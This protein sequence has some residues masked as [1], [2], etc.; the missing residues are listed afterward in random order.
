MLQHSMNW[1]R[2]RTSNSN[3]SMWTAESMV[4]TLLYLRMYSTNFS[5]LSKLDPVKAASFVL[6]TGVLWPIFSEL[7][8][9]VVTS[10][11]CAFI[12]FGISW[13]EP[14]LQCHLYLWS[15]VTWINLHTIREKWSVLRILISHWSLKYGLSRGIEATDI[16]VSVARKLINGNLMNDNTSWCKFITME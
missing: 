11:T 14:C 8:Q 9:F 3:D 15:A 5:V 6:A 12:S 16:I 7:Q 10:S 2:N 4:G 13:T 1:L